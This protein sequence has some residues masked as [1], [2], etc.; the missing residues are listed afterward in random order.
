MKTCATR[1]NDTRTVS[2]GL[3]TGLSVRTCR[4]SCVS[5]VP[6]GNGVDFALPTIPPFLPFPLLFPMMNRATIERNESTPRQIQKKKSKTKMTNKVI[7]SNSKS[8]TDQMP[9]RAVRIGAL[10][11][12]IRSAR[13]FRK[14]RFDAS[15][16]PTA[17]WH[18]IPIQT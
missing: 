7:N 1:L 15:P 2:P 16:S 8:R 11:R 14:N 9:D 3:Y 10:R 5:L 12:S 6:G 4:T 17:S 13:W 18:S